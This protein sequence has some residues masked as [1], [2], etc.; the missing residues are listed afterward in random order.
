M[1]LTAFLL[2]VA[3][4]SLLESSAGHSHFLQRGNVETREAKRKERGCSNEHIRRYFQHA[5]YLCEAIEKYCDG[6]TGSL[7]EI[8]LMRERMIQIMNNGLSDAVFLVVKKETTKKDVLQKF[9]ET[10]VNFMAE[11]RDEYEDLLENENLPKR[12]GI[13]PFGYDYRST[14]TC[15]TLSGDNR[16]EAKVEDKKDKPSRRSRNR[17]QRRGGF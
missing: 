1:K 8:N 2:L 11:M 4:F 5:G 9:R 16:E 12:E 3:I 10:V 7:H 6:R 17:L 13:E 15:H 14:W